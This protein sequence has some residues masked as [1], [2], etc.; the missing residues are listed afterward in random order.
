MVNELIDG[1]PVRQAEAEAAAIAS[2]QARIRLWDGTL[3]M[4]GGRT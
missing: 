3:A 2:V 1:D 4:L